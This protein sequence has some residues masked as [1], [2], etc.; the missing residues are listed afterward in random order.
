M[1]KL[2]LLSLVLVFVMLFST[3]AFAEDAG[4]GSIEFIPLEVDDTDE[5]QP[6]EGIGP[7]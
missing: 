1:K 7:E 2:G 4:I 5:V 6:L 3:L